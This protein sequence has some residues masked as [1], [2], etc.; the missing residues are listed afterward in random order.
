MRMLRRRHSTD[1]N[2]G[3]DMNARLLGL[4][5]AL[6][7]PIASASSQVLAQSKPLTFQELEVVGTPDEMT[8]VRSVSARLKS[9]LTD[10]AAFVK[11][12]RDALGAGRGREARSLI[13]QVAQVPGAEVVI[14]RSKPT[15]AVEPRARFHLAAAAPGEISWAA[16]S[17]NPWYVMYTDKD[18]TVCVGSSCSTHLKYKGYTLVP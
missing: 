13:A 2:N 11:Q 5:A 8:L 16:A 6:V 10:D 14:A 4:L 9:K 12:V 3:Q 1:T 7:A 18:W 17:Y 15:S